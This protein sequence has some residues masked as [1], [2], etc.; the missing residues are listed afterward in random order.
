[1]EVKKTNVGASYIQVERTDNPTTNYDKWCITTH[2]EMDE[3]GNCDWYEAETVR[4][5]FFQQVE[6]IFEYDP[7]ILALFRHWW[8]SLAVEYPVE[9]CTT[10][11]RYIDGWGFEFIVQKDISKVI[12][13]YDPKNL[14]RACVGYLWEVPGGDIK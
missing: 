9:G 7:K 1:M 14:E 4:T 10:C 5:M 8:G 6:E 13:T 12:L 11:G 3:S 2:Y